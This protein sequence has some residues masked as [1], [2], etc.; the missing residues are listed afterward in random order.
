MIPAAQSLLTLER[1]L[2]VSRFLWKKVE[3]RIEHEVGKLQNDSWFFGIAL[4]SNSADFKQR[5]R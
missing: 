1:I 4:G 3:I 5:R 2:I